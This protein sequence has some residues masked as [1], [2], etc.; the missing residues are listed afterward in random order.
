MLVE[1]QNKLA[2]VVPNLSIKLKEDIEIS[3]ASGSIQ[4]QK[5]ATIQVHFLIF[6]IFIFL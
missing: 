1:E 3:P 4:P 5:E 2:K 6:V